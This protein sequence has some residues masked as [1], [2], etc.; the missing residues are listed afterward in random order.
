MKDVLNV[1]AVERTSFSDWKLRE[2]PDQRF[3][4]LNP[5]VAKQQEEE[6]ESLE[7]KINDLLFG[8]I[9]GPA[10]KTFSKC[11][12]INNLATSM[13]SSKV[14]LKTPNGASSRTSM[15]EE[16]RE[17]LMKTL[18]KLFKNIK[19]GFIELLIAEGPN[20]KL[21]KAPIAKAAK[22]EL[23]RDIPQIEYQNVRVK[24]AN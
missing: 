11:N 6:W 2:L 7:K 17:A 15:P 9:N 21:K 18:Q 1:I 20:A 5:M 10:T 19:E 16:T 23:K 14:A 8:G 24:L 3:K 12:V 4:K 13:S 22:M